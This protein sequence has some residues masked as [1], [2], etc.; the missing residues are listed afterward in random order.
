[1]RMDMATSGWENRPGSSIQ[2][3]ETAG[4][5]PKSTTAG[6][7]FT[8][9]LFDLLPAFTGSL[10]NAAQQFVLLTFD[11]HE[12]VFGQFGPFLLELSLDL[13]PAAFEF[14]FVHGM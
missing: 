13:I 2:G 9:K 5:C 11:V 4:V 7:A 10:L 8:N 1:M 14:E 6:T 12:I 3:T